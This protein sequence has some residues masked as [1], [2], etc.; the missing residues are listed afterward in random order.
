MASAHNQIIHAGVNEDTSASAN[1]GGTSEYTN[2]EMEDT[3]DHN[4]LP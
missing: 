4:D 3:Q 1:Y 2:L